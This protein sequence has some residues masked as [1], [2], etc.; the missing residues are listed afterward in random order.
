M[1]DIETTAS[2][3]GE[4]NKL[5]EELHGSEVVQQAKTEAF[6]QWKR[7][8]AGVDNALTELGRVKIGLSEILGDKYYL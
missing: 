3:I 1:N 8:S 5:S 2:E 6:E 4:V 7:V